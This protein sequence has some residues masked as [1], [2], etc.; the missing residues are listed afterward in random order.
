MAECDVFTQFR[1]YAVLF[2]FRIGDHDLGPPNMRF[3][4]LIDHRGEISLLGFECSYVLRVVELNHRNN[5]EEPWSARQFAIYNKYNACS[6][7]STW[8]FI[9]LTK[10]TEARLQ[11][12]LADANTWG[13]FNPFELH[14]LLSDTVLA[15]WGPYFEWLATRAAELE[16]RI[17]V[18]RIRSEEG[19]LLVDFADRR[20]LK[21]LEDKILDMIVMLDSTSNTLSSI[22]EKYAARSTQ[23]MLHGSDQCDL[24]DDLIVQTFKEQHERTLQLKSK[25]ETLRV[26]LAGTIELISSSLELNNGLDLSILAGEAQNETRKGLRD[27]IA[28]KILTI[29]T[30]VY[31]PTTVVANFFSTEFVMQVSSEDGKST[32]LAV[33]SNWWI[34]LVASIPLTIATL[35]IWWFFLQK[36][37]YDKYPSWFEFLRRP[38]QRIFGRYGSASSERSKTYSSV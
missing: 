19:V 7:T 2:R 16:D 11:E 36:Q 38:F 21:H 9:A 27:A 28:M 25:A 31:L 3:R 12:Y 13:L 15:N 1:E 6:R 30:L 29:V 8:I 18:S 26:K 14:S 23:Q 20:K 4:R 17:M 32:H 37:A 22:Q 10:D 34:L 33:A 24:S 5:R 35:Y